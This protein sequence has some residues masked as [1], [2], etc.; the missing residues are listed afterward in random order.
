MTADERGFT[1][2][3]A[4][5]GQCGLMLDWANE[6]AP[7]PAAPRWLRVEKVT[8]Y[9]SA[10]VHARV[11]HGDEV[12]EV[13]G[14]ATAS[15]DDGRLF[16]QSAALATFRQRPLVLAFRR[17]PPSRAAPEPRAPAELAPPAGREEAAAAEA[18]GGPT[19]VTPP[20]A[21]PSAVEVEF[22]GQWYAASVEKRVSSGVR[23]RFE[24]DGSTTL[25]H[26]DEIARRVRGAGVEELKAV[27][28]SDAAEVST[29]SSLRSQA[30]ARTS[31][32][33]AAHRAGGCVP[34]RNSDAGAIVEHGFVEAPSLLGVELCEELSVYSMDGAT[35]IS[36][37]KEQT[38]RG[39]L[40]TR[41]AEQI[42]ASPV[43]RHA[44][45]AAFGTSEFDVLT[46]KLIEATPG[47]DRDA[48]PQHPH[49]HMEHNMELIGI[50]HVRE[51]QLPTRCLP[52]KSA[53]ERAV[54]PY[55]TGVVKRC[56]LCRAERPMHDKDVRRRVH[57]KRACWTCADG[58]WVCGVAC[59][60]DELRRDV[61]LVAAFDE[62]LHPAETI[63]AMRPCGDSTPA[64]GDGMLALPT[65]IHAGPGA[66][67]N[68]AKRRVLFFSVRPRF[69][70]DEY[71][72]PPSQDAYDD[73]A[74]V[75]AGWV[76]FYGE[77]EITAERKREVL[78]GYREL[79]YDMQAF[80]DAAKD[81]FKE[82]FPSKRKRERPDFDDEDRVNLIRLS[83][84]LVGG[85]AT[86]K[87]LKRM[88]D[89]LGLR[90]DGPLWKLKNRIEAKL[91][92]LKFEQN[93]SFVPTADDVRL[94]LDAFNTKFEH[95]PPVRLAAVER[96]L[97]DLTSS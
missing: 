39:E 8:A 12:C 46:P 26:N 82:R 51:G 62:L 60:E 76:L 73:G 55:P 42:S 19:A 17:R 21:H 29:S 38:V 45:M 24:E 86:L 1:L 28:A 84:R 70:P 59:A 52:Y 6:P 4:D 27:A 14:V 44:V 35:V 20:S 90:N 96:V 87:P 30:R 5:A 67:K 54:A 64:A 63:A 89:A 74:Q 15:L 61:T 31:A 56:A 47:V 91:R 18:D 13:C 49:A 80:Y 85:A 88:C 37:A 53:A 7:A 36:Q 11:E 33:A 66:V 93:D 77:K 3:I 9:A 58:G 16:S 50:A 81:E 78:T 32:E 65:L 72:K 57:L 69:S 23:V 43:V 83:R 41:T 97:R 95:E 94:D 22:H 10:E 2:T 40:W 34:H 48:L 79:G 75:H 92:E 71:H 68:G 25:I